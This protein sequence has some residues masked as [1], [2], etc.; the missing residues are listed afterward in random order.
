MAFA[1][2][3]LLPARVDDSRVDS[4]EGE[5][6]EG[7]PKK[8]RQSGVNLMAAVH[9]C[10]RPT[11]LP[12]VSA[13]AI[14]G[15]A[16]NVHRSQFSVILADGY[17]VD[18]EAAGRI[19]AVGAMV[20]LAANTVGVPLLRS[21]LSERELL[22]GS[23]AVLAGCFGAFAICTAVW[24]IMV[25][26]IP[27]ALCSTVLYTVSSAMLSNSVRDDE[28]GTAV[29]ISHSTRSA[30]GVIAPTIGG[31]LL[32]EAGVPAVGIAAAV[33]VV[34]AIPLA[35]RQPGMAPKKQQ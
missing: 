28:A 21:R 22:L 16:V 23:L 5:T 31:Y 15:L 27:M 34:A 2:L 8:D 9:M 6:K 35:M 3:I 4:T 13:V 26:M 20:G 30:T 32:A 14:A 19:T 11:L 33:L 1:S 25:V 29:S 24:Q 10:L 17:G 7:E 18:A 12:I